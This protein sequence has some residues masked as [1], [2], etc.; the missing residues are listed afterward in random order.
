MAVKTAKI[1]VDEQA[2]AIVPV[3][4]ETPELEQLL[5]AGYPDIGSVENAER[6]I[7]ERAKNPSLYPFETLRRAEAFLQAYHANPAVVSTVPGW[8]R[9]TGR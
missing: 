4:K 8:R 3:T 2:V 1:A 7:A 9:K 5:S 6:I